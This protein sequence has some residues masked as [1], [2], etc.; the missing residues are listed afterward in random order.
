MKFL[1]VEVFYSTYKVLTINLLFD[2][3]NVNK[4]KQLLYCYSRFCKGT[5]VVCNIKY[6][7][8]LNI[9][10]IDM[11]FVIILKRPIEKGKGRH[12]REFMFLQDKIFI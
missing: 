2:H 11:V 12:P 9:K 8:E 10:W 5:N 3:I 1:L 4:Y 6:F 7:R